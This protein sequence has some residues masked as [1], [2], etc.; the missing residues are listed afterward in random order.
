MLSILLLRFD[1][2]RALFG[3]RPRAEMYHP[4][5]RTDTMAMKIVTLC[6][7]LAQDIV[8]MQEKIKQELGSEVGEQSDVVGTNS[9]RETVS[10]RR[11]GG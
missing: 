10:A 9:R 7:E 6:D 8:K 3:L 2:T 1:A 5:L 11:Q 4:K